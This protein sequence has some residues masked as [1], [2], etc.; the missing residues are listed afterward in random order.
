MTPE[1][2][3]DLLLECFSRGTQTNLSCTTAPLHWTISA[4]LQAQ[5]TTLYGPNNSA[6]LDADGDGYTPL[7]GDLNDALSSIHPGATEVLNGVDDDCDGV[8]DDLLYNATTDFP[9]TLSSALAVNFPFKITGTISSSSDG[10]YF[11]ITLGATTKVRF[12]LKSA[13]AFAGWLFIYDANGNWLTYSYCGAGSQSDLDVTFLPG[14]WR[15]SVSQNSASAPGAYQL[16]GAAATDWPAYT[17]PGRPSL[18]GSNLWRFIS[19][20]VPTN[21]V[22][23]PNA[24]ARFWVAGFG[25]VGTNALG[26]SNTSAFTWTAP[27]NLPPAETT[28]RI[29][30]YQATNPVTRATEA[31][32]LTGIVPAT[33]TLVSN[34]DFTLSWS[35]AS[36]GLSVGSATNLTGAWA[37]MTN[38]LLFTNGQFSTTTPR[39]NDRA[40]FFRLQTTGH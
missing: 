17:Y 23:A 10:D 40:R 24:Q 26:T 38:S 37:S 39:G 18:V 8:V 31:L 5:L 11:K 6:C 29:Q 7:Q 3:N 16:I 1:Q 12:S 2:K 25:W 35:A 13:G 30:F 9:N 27:S 34:R 20:S 36:P 33:L 22:G 28:F 14:T 21:L 19:G 15:F 4:G 32:P